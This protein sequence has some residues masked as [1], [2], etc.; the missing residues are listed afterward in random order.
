MAASANI[1][2]NVSIGKTSNS[3]LSPGVYKDVKDLQNQE[4]LMTKL[5]NSG[6]LIQDVKRAHNDPSGG[7]IF[8]IT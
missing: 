6:N 5:F 3:N 4:N 7:Q 2:S 1:S 8:L